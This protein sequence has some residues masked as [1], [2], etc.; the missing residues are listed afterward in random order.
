MPGLQSR[1]EWLASLKVGDTVAISIRGKIAHREIVTSA[2]R[3]LIAIGKYSRRINFRRKD[4]MPCG[5]APM[6][7]LFRLEQP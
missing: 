6:R 1:E 2:P 5:H 3:T 7:R 4:G